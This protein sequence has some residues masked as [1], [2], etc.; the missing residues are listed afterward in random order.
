LKIKTVKMAY[1]DFSL[2][3]FKQAF[4]IESASVQLFNTK[5]VKSI[6]PSQRLKD[7]IKDA[8]TL[9]IVTEKAKSELI[10]TPIIKE[11][12][13]RN[14]NFNFFSG[15]SFNIDSSLGLTGIPDFILAKSTQNLIEIEAPVFCLVEAKNGVVEEGIGQCAAEMYA[16]R[17]FNQQMNKPY[18]TIYG[19]VTNAF[20]W[21]FMK[22]ED[23]T[24][25]IDQDRY[26]L[27]DLPRLLGIMQHIIE[28]Y[29]T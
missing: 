13:R 26:F 27:N 7:D 9:P 6:K 16:A 8:E 4:Q 19:A 1:K 23:N 25:Y 12:K 2:I 5:T 14:M 3:K 20:D 11:I 21:V 29:P 15:F 28:K 17:L 22:L 24:I 18:E 10:I